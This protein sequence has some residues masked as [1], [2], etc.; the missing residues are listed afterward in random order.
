MYQPF[1]N[2]FECGLS[3]IYR[4]LQSSL[5]FYSTSLL[6]EYLGTSH[7]IRL[8]CFTCS[9]N[10]NQRVLYRNQRVLSVA[11]YCLSSTHE[12]S[13]EESVGLSR[14]LWLERNESVYRLPTLRDLLLISLWRSL[15]PTPT[16]QSLYWELLICNKKIS[17]A[18]FV[19]LC[20]KCF[21]HIKKILWFLKIIMWYEN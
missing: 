13:T 15:H 5:L 2:R 11:Q 6:H 12:I 17:T 4:N 14:S 9:P 21:I 10:V 1:Y 7:W 16:K 19:E 20:I 8:E 3:T 18:R